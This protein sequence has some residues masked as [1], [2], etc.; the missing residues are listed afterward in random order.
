[1][2]SGTFLLKKCHIDE[3]WVED[4]SNYTEVMKEKNVEKFRCHFM[5]EPLLV[6]NSNVVNI[7][8]KFFN[9]FLLVFY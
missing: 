5:T 8:N 2:K 4:R 6:E 7:L 9:L 1:M 3:D